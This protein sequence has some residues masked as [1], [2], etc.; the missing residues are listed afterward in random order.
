MPERRRSS[1][2]IVALGLASALVPACS[3]P[4][5]QPTT[6]VVPPPPGHPLTAAELALRAQLGVPADAKSVIVF[7]QNA[8]MDIDW[9]QT[10]PDYYT[11]FVGNLLTEARQILQQQP[12]AFYSVAEM[13][14]LE[15][16][17]QQHPEE[18]AP[19]VAASK[20]GSLHIVGGGMTSPDTLLPETEM[21]LRDY[22]YGIQFAEDTLGAH[23]T[24]AWLPDSFGHAA[25]APDVLAAAGFQSVAFSRIDGSWPFFEQLFQ[26]DPPPVLGST[27]E[28]L[29]ALGSADFVW[30]GPGGGSVIAHFMASRGLY[31]A[32]DNIDYDEEIEPAG[33]HTGPFMGD[34]TTFT[35]GAIDGYISA[36]QPYTKTPYIFIPVGCDFA[37]PKPQLVSYLDG[38]NMRRYPTTGVWAV[39]APFDLYSDLVSSWR[40]VLPEMAVDLTPYFMG[41]YG[42][43]ADIKR[44]TR[45]AARPFFMAETFA[46]ALGDAGQTI[47]LAA[48]PALKILTRTD[49]H[50]FVTGTSADPVVASDQLPLLSQAETAGQAELA[51]VAAAIAQRIPIQPGAIARVLAL[52]GSG[53]AQSDAMTFPLPITGGV[54]PPLRAL[55]GGQDV[56]VEIVGTPL[57]TD[58]TATIRLGLPGMQPFSWRAVDLVVGQGTRPE[59]LVTL[60]LLDMN[61]A[62][63]TGAAVTRVVLSNASVTATWNSGAGGFVLTSLIMNGKES[64]AGSSVVLNDYADMGGLWRL[65]NEMAGCTLTPMSAPPPAETVEVLDATGLGACVVFHGA[66]ADREA[67]L[68]AGATG[69]SLAV[70]TGAA[71]GTTRTVSFSLAVPRD[72][73]LTTAEPAGSTV[74]PAEHIFTPTFWSAVGWAQVGDLAILL[75]QS[76]GVRMS[77]PGA[78]ELM[79]A[80]DARVEQCDVEGGDGSDTT[81]HRIEW[82]IQPASTAAEAEQAAQAFNRPI[83]LEVVPLTQAPTLDLPGETSL[84]GVS[85]AGIVSALK[86]AD[87]GGGVI[88]RA[89]LMPGPVTITLPPSLVGKQMTRVDVAERDSAPL[90]TAGTTLVLDRETFGA[91]ASVRLQ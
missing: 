51:Q 86:P 16:H 42:S 41:F 54:V 32:G 58:T 2:V 66:D 10:F 89:V 31:C 11:N 34:S 37:S 46:T 57:P 5:E 87:R 65:G 68:T 74:R 38:Y 45:D 39:A 21:L 13:A 36:M 17:L 85:G 91:I 9:Q 4:K 27:A 79:A 47:T 64:L 44:G 75:R 52:N 7:G 80:R 72:A 20:A 28:A 53:V 63:A 82:R 23:P 59:P 43:R 67:S 18:L 88:L 56:P 76:T 70:T 81:I 30:K 35:D 77:T 1:L 33:G 50:D 40:D 78:L 69:L 60:A 55:A 19:L 61:G 22:L 73:A 6:T 29:L 71:M 25:T 48:A 15:Y 90:G 62:P 24:A 83:D 26:H 49:H 3:T 14:F 8:H 84:L 12:R